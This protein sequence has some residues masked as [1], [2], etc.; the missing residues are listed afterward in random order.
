M[1]FPGAASP[2]RWGSLPWGSVDVVEFVGFSSKMGYFQ[3]SLRRR[4]RLVCLCAATSSSS[5]S[6]S[7]S[8][9]S[10]TMLL[11]LLFFDCTHTRAFVS[12]EK[13]WKRQLGNFRIIFLH[14]RGAYRIRKRSHLILSLNSIDSYRSPVPCK[15]DK[16]EASMKFFV[17]LLH[18]HQCSGTLGMAAARTP[19]QGARRGNKNNK[20]EGENSALHE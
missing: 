17:L 8:L 13:N 18:A 7:F 3:D 16:N 10:F 11:L 4:R 6:Q 20:W 1:A 19:A 12:V 15:Q 2:S 14:P 9:K 5:V